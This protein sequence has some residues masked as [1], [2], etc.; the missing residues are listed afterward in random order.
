MI[1]GHDIAKSVWSFDCQIRVHEDGVLVKTT[2]NLLTLVCVD[3]NVVVQPQLRTGVGVLHV[4]AT[5][6][7][8]IVV[9]LRVGD[10]LALQIRAIVTTDVSQ[11]RLALEIEVF[12]TE[13]HRVCSRFDMQTRGDNPLGIG[14]IY[15]RALISQMNVINRDV[16]RKLSKRSSRV[17]CFDFV[18]NFLHLGI[19]IRVDV[20]ASLNDCFKVLVVGRR[21]TYT[22]AVC[23]CIAVD[24]DGVNDRRILCGRRSQVILETPLQNRS[25]QT[26]SGLGQFT[27]RECNICR[28]NSN[29]FVRNNRVITVAASAVPLSY[30]LRGILFRPIVLT[31][32][33]GCVILIIV[34]LHHQSLSFHGSS[35]NVR[36]IDGQQ[37]VA[38]LVILCIVFITVS[39]VRGFHLGALIVE[40]IACDDT[41]LVACPVVI[42]SIQRQFDG[43]VLLS[44]LLVSESVGTPESAGQPLIIMNLAFGLSAFF[45]RIDRARFNFDFCMLTAVN[46]VQ[47]ISAAKCGRSFDILPIIVIRSNVL[48][49]DIV[50]L[51]AKTLPV[52]GFKCEDC[53]V[54][55]HNALVRRLRHGHWALFNL[56][57]TGGFRRDDTGV[58]GRVDF[59]LNQIVGTQL[60][61]MTS[62]SQHGK[63]HINRAVRVVID[64]I[65]AVMEDGCSDDTT[66]RTVRG[67]KGLIGNL[68]PV[69]NN[70]TCIAQVDDAIVP[71]HS[72]VA[73]RLVVDDTGALQDFGG[74]T[75]PVLVVFDRRC[76]NL[77][78][79]QRN[80]LA[81]VPEMRRNLC[82]DRTVL[83]Y[84]IAVLIIDTGTHNRGAALI[85]TGQVGNAILVNIVDYAAK[86]IAFLQQ[87]KVV[88]VADMDG[89][90]FVNL[91]IIEQLGVAQLTVDTGNTGGADRRSATAAVFEDRVPT[92]FLVRAKVPVV[93]VTGTISTESAGLVVEQSCITRHF[94]IEILRVPVTGEVLDGFPVGGVEAQLLEIQVL[95]QFIAIVQ[96]IPVAAAI[97]ESRQNLLCVCRV[98]A[99]DEVRHLLVALVSGTDFALFTLGN[100]HERIYAQLHFLRRCF[101]LATN[102]FNGKVTNLV[103]DKVA[104]ASKVE[105]VR[106][107]ATVNSGLVQFAQACIGEI[108]GTTAILYPNIIECNLTVTMRQCSGNRI[109]LIELVRPVGRRT[110]FDVG[111]C[112]SLLIGITAIRADIQTTTTINGGFCERSRR[113][114]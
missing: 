83:C 29:V 78:Q 68:R 90:A 81:V 48:N 92:V 109:S 45:Q 104:G 27:G 7:I 51:V 114:T 77:Q 44:T 23:V 70:I 53:L 13:V 74:L 71:S 91:S 49:L 37:T 63:L 69:C 66:D 1:P 18:Y 21:Q 84:L 88:L 6:Y 59:T 20:V 9:S 26:V 3:T 64:T 58:D 2:S 79:F 4:V 42:S 52:I 50:S 12:R 28:V 108:R 99:V 46:R 102:A 94:H 33:A 30:L 106:T 32:I 100:P 11:I 34:L 10:G 61:R 73:D 113:K 8:V 95:H 98:D 86:V 43:G 76:F 82:N 57:D 5:V 110:V 105:V 54:L 111:V 40:A 25:Q 103:H 17:F 24:V 96:R 31:K 36:S 65:V 47:R 19:G 15:I 41:E 107:L 16:S 101:I 35:R 14:V 75:F 85:N 56:D 87:F 60:N 93:A 55:C 22:V 80:R 89:V 97:G 39:A 67:G 62:V 38:A 112:H 72:A